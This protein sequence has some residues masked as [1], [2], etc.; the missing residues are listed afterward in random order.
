[1]RRIAVT[2]QKGGVGKTTT[3]ANLAA[4]L[5]L[6][7]RRVIVVDLDT[8]ANLTL[9]FTTD[10]ESIQRST[11][12]VLRGDCRFAE[13][14]A[15]T[16]LPLLR[17]VPATMDLAGVEVELANVVGR[18]MLLRDAILQ[19]LHEGATPA[20]VLPDGVVVP[21]APAPS[22]PDFI[23]FD[24]PPSL[25]L[26]S[27]NALV[28]AEEVLIP[29]QAE[30]LALQGVSKLLE[31]VDLVRRRLNPSLEITGVLA[32]MVNPRTNLSAEVL[33]EIESFFGSKVFAT[34]IREN[35]RLAEA[36]S[37]GKTIFTYAG[38]SK[39]ASDYLRLAGEILEREIAAREKAAVSSAP[40]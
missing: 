20:R 3:A 33:A 17:Y 21:A 27:L 8:Q 30:F 11:Y 37:H 6:L 12:H 7:G 38:D 34:R 31:V 24:C 10:P 16:P 32:C 26:L 1:V 22:P 5:A 40:A 39:G 19:F 23:F 15:P 35:V 25:G 29:L 14:L 18:E 2:N 13:A 4:A 36:P 28:A 9:H